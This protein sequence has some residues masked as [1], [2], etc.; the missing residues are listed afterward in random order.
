M[1]KFNKNPK[2]EQM[3]AD[4]LVLAEQNLALHQHF[5]TQD[6][7]E[8]AITKESELEAFE[9]IDR[10]DALHDLENI[11]ATYDID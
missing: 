5:F 4:A 9:N 2:V 10:E 8:Y 11:K 3:R 1:A 6:G 7:I